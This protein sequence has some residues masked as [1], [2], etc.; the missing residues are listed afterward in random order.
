MTDS[1]IEDIKTAGTVILLAS[2]LLVISGRWNGAN[3]VTE[4]GIVLDEPWKWQPMPDPIS[5]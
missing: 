4:S 1:R 2:A 3:W 5:T